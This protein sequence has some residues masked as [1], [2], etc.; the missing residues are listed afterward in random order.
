M[1]LQRTMQSNFNTQTVKPLL[2]AQYV[3]YYRIQSEMDLTI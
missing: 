2:K 3:V 1:P